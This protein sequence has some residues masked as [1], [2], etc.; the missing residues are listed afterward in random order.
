MCSG[1]AT[2]G[3]AAGAAPS[4]AVHR[5][6]AV[7]RRHR[8][9]ALPA[10]VILFAFGSLLLGCRS[11]ASSPPAPPPSDE[12]RA[13]A[14][15]DPA[16]P[17]PPR[18]E[19]VALAD[20]VA[21]ASSRAGRNERGAALARLAAD[22]R[23]RAYRL[24]QAE[25][26]AREALE[27][28]AASASAAAGT[29][30]GCEADRRRALLAGE[31]ARD[32]A[33]SYRE[34]YLASRR[35]AV[36]APR[37]PCHAALERTLA[38]AFAYRPRGDA[39]RALE[40]EGDLASEAA[41]RGVTAPSAFV[42]S[43]P[44]SGEVSPESAPP[45][46]A[47]RS[48]AAEGQVVVTPKDTTA[49]KE[50]VKITAIE[51]FGSEKGGRVVIHLSGPT[52]FQVGTLA[53]DAAAGKDARVF[54]DVARASFKGV[55]RETEVSGVVRRVRL[56]AQE[57]GGTRVVLDLA[58]SLYRRVFYLPD[59]F[60]IVVDVSTRPPVRKDEQDASGKREVRRVVLDPGHGGNDT[61]AVGPTGL[62]EKDVTLDIAHRAATI[63][64][65][66]LGVETMLTRDDD[67]FVPLDLRT[68]RANAF[69]ADLFVSIHCNASENGQARGPM[70]FS[71]DRVR[72]PEGLAMRVAARE[73]A[74]RPRKSG[75]AGDARSID[76]EMALIASN[77][78]V[79]DLM[80]RSRHVADL[81]QRAALA[82]LGVRWPDTKDQ[83]TKT[84]GFFVLV[85]ADMPAVLFETSFISN[86]DDEARLATA[87]YRQKLAD[88]VANAIRAYRE[89]K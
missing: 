44:P 83:G 78:D 77:L 28:Y 19:V 68:A 55:P 45:S 73:N 53:A 33:V 36:L 49:A 81:V 43:P 11:G 86:P 71:L 85:G 7:Q 2:R 60:R 82:S 1:P 40:H 64:S 34:T 38:V 46:P 8:I 3:V 56:G 50:P 26:D 89:G 88:A 9:P 39:L 74:S 52:T 69:H 59:P 84:A 66:E 72:D 17:L 14:L 48:A 4:F 87:D 47:A 29:L 20:A 32:A 35:Q 76:E 75:E 21:I 25:A 65:R 41:S 24:D 67:T 54:V 57:N 6:T 63:V 16:A 37:T 22:L 62:K 13:Q 10:A 27:L 5:R 15:L 70:T 80:A 79:G 30:Q 51:P 12:Q 18:A 58:A 61:G 31:L 42:A 23:A